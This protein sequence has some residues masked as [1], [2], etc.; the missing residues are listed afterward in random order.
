MKVYCNICGHELEF[1]N[2]HIDYEEEIPLDTTLIITDSKICEG[3][4]EEIELKLEI[5][6]VNNE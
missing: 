4:D 1:E 3:C 5:G 6:V 2:F